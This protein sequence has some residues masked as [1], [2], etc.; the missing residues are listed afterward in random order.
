MWVIRG[1]HHKHRP[2]PFYE[3]VVFYAENGR[4]ATRSGGGQSASG[5][6]PNEREFA[7]RRLRAGDDNRDVGVAKIVI[8]IA[9]RILILLDTACAPPSLHF[10]PPLFVVTYILNLH[11]PY[12]TLAEMQVWAATVDVHSIDM[13]EDVCKF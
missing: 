13:L 6:P 8:W 4:M 9:A 5:R 12:K 11:A 7:Q 2:Y 1:I 3:R 10:P